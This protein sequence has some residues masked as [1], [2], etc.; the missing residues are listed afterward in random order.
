MKNPETNYLQKQKKRLHTRIISRKMDLKK[1]CSFKK[2]QRHRKK[3]FLEN[4]FIPSPPLQKW[5]I[6]CHHRI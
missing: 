5:S 6:P 1:N 4:V 3:S 2:R